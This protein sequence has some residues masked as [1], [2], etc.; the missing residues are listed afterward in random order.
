MIHKVALSG[1]HST[2]GLSALTGRPARV[3]DWN[4]KNGLQHFII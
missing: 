4:V 2:R 1:E 3:K